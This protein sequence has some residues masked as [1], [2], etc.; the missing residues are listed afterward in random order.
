[1]LQI[2][3]E[4]FSV[5]VPPE[6]E[7]VPNLED[8][9]VALAKRGG[10]GRLQFSQPTGSEAAPAEVSPQHLLEMITC[11]A[12]DRG[13]PS[14]ED[15]ALESGPLRIAAASFPRGSDFL[16]AWQISD[17]GNVALATYACDISE[18]HVEVA[19]CEQIVRSLQFRRAAA[20]K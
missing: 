8:G 11:F 1:M 10:V 12:H 5:D 3:F 19:D 13:L 6:W 4:Q 15:V 17:G 18:K 20:A 14:P 2:E 16:R 7:S 9:A